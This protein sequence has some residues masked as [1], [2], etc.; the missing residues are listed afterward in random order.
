MN[1]R[2]QV[3]R[4]FVSASFSNIKKCEFVGIFAG[5]FL[6]EAG[7]SELMKSALVQLFATILL[8]SIGLP[9]AAAH[10]PKIHTSRENGR[11]MPLPKS[12]DMFHFIIYGDRTGGTPEGIEVLEEAV[13]DTNLLDPDLVMTV[14]DLVQGY[15]E[16]P[17]WMEQMREFRGVMSKLAMPWFPVA[18]NHDIYWRPGSG[19]EPAPPQEHEDNYEKHF[20][21]LWY[22]FEH[23]GSGFLVLYTDEGP[24]PKKFAG[25][26]NVQMSDTQLAWLKAALGEMNALDNV[27]VFLHHPRWIG[28]GYEGSNWD[29]V[30]TSL[31]E[32]GNVRAVFAGHIHRLRYDGVK[33]G[34]GY[35]ALATTGGAMPGDYPEI[36]YVHHMNLVTV[37]KKD[38]SVAILPVGAVIDPTIYTPDRLQD[39]DAVRNLPLSLASDPI[40]IQSD[41]K[42]VGAYKLKATNPAKAAVELTVSPS[43]SERGWLVLPDHQ[44]LTIAPGESAEVAFTY[45]FTGASEALSAVP[46]LKIDTDYLDGNARITLPGRTKKLEVD[47]A[48][49]S[50][51]FF[52]TDAHQTLSLG[53]ESSALRVN[54]AAFDLPD[55]AF[56]IECWAYPEGEMENVA[57]L[58]KTEGSDYGIHVQNGMPQFMVYLD[59]KYRQAVS[60]EVLPAGQWSHVAGVFDGESVSLFLNGRRV[61]HS[62]ASGERKR[63]DKPFFIGADPDGNGKPTRS[64]AGRIDNVRLSKNARYTEETF[65][66]EKS[67][68]KPDDTTVLL[69]DCDRAVSSF[70]PGQSA[71]GTVSGLLVGKKAQLVDG[72]VD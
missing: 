43:D 11:A 44:H 32:A 10:D 56:T 38:F 53:G 37:R 16:P 20:G 65:E 59:G 2:F 19:S 9:P 40:L 71:I 24:S 49:V 7:R 64:F 47:L 15:N 3:N 62:E 39:L 23:K 69:F 61:A 42:A 21:P 14:G 57:L 8:V 48:P 55:G 27:F 45:A 36:G 26:E 1:D 50:E 72:M 33:D 5:I 46:H 70:V 60:A 51:D 68:F 58:S 18:G 34:I 4:E 31:V 54:S 35:Y 17:Q 12:D 41:G 28:G 25:P 66:P 6:Y 67:E 63:N 13:T 52:T 30:H 22:W 29:A